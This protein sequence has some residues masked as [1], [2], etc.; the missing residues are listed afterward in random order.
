MIIL[1]D[2]VDVILSHNVECRT[3]YLAA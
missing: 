2:A 1:L 3:F